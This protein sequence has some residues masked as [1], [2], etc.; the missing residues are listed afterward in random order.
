VNEDKSTRYHRLRRFVELATLC[1]W[2]MFL[3]GVLG[4]DTP[5]DWIDALAHLAFLRA[6]PDL[7]CNSVVVASYTF[8]VVVIGESIVSPLSLYSEFLLQR[9]FFL[10]RRRL[11]HWIKG[12]AKKT[13]VHVAVVTFGSVV[14]YAAMWIWPMWWWLISGGLFAVLTITLTHF[15]PVITIPRLYH[16]R[17]LGRNEL[18]NRLE[19]LLRRTGAPAM[20]IEELR[21]GSETPRPNA[22]LVGI[23][24]TSRVLLTDTLLSDYSDDEIEVV[25]AHEIGHFMHN[26]VWKTMAFETAAALLI[27]GAAQLTFYQA[28]P[29]FGLVNLPDVVGFP[30]LVLAG[31]AVLLILTPI[32]NMISRHHE[33]QADRYAL[34]VTKKPEAFISGLRRLATQSLAEEQPSRLAEWLF[35]S[36]PPLSDRLATANARKL[37]SV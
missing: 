26:D 11:A 15:A 37:S 36:H 10:S 27:F 13:I 33:R 31:G 14:L 30:I 28:G 34:A 12:H 23:G 22:A 6:M 1:V 25:L 5:R 7:V 3:V 35:Y 9:R 19:L 16:L 18:K 21:L 20:S 32:R 17:P 2:V 29:S 8:V 4:S 24:S